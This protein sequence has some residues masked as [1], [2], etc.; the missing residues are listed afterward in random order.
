MN[1]D[2]LALVT[3]K[4]WQ[5]QVEEL[6]TI[7]GWAS[8]HDLSGKTSGSAARGFPDLIAIRGAELIALELKTQ[9][10]RVAPEQKQWIMRFDGVETS[11]GHMVRP[12]E[13]DWLDA[14][15]RRTHTQLVFD[16]DT[17][18]STGTTGHVDK[19]LS[20]PVDPMQPSP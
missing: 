4:T 5:R 8:F 13:F 17:R 14:R 16:T 2:V 20:Q 12:S 9:K 7:H 15:L 19:L 1:R 3:E 6:L 11:E 10:G 18:N